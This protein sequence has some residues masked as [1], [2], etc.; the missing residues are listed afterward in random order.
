MLSSVTSLAVVASRALAPRLRFDNWYR[1]FQN[2]HAHP[3]SVGLL[4]A[5]QHEVNRP[6]GEDGEVTAAPLP[7]TLVVDCALTAL[8]LRV[9]LGMP[10]FDSMGKLYGAVARR[11]G[12]GSLPARQFPTIRQALEATTTRPD[13]KVLQTFDS[14][15][16]WRAWSMVF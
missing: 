3:V 16:S 13:K 8:Y 2:P 15:R 11:F 5:G 7:R 14:S 4:K 9:I 6:D 10:S 1:E 12:L